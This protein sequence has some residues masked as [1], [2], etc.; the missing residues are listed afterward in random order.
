MLTIVNCPLLSGVPALPVLWLYC[1]VKG[2]R[3]VVDWHN[4]SHTILQVIKYKCI[5]D[6]DENI[7]TYSIVKNIFMV[8]WVLYLGRCIDDDGGGGG[9]YKISMISIRS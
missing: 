5:N 9:S 1:A 2:T 8:V 6:G 3:L 4:Y 7:L